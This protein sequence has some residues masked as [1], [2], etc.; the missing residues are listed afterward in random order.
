MSVR[1][2]AEKFARAWDERCEE[3]GTTD[4]VDQCWP[5]DFESVWLCGDC[6]RELEDEAAIERDPEKFF[7]VS[8]SDFG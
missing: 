4:D 2:Q 5:N 7:G 1:E 3:C 6:R 8:R